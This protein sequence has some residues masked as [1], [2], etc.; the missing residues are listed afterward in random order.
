MATENTS[1]KDT[2]PAGDSN[3]STEMVIGKINTYQR[4]FLIVAG[5]ILALL[6]VIAVAGA[7]GDQ[8]L[9]S[10]AY[11]NVDGAVVH[12]DYQVDS[13]S[14]AL[15]KNV[16]GS[17]AVSENPENCCFCKPSFNCGTTCLPV[18]GLCRCRRCPGCTPPC[19]SF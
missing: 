1:L 16:F 6:V 4:T 5:S 14:L 8:H 9:Q 2:T 3:T 19:N 11:E 12:L 15:T 13:A 10:T 7:S 18:L 17:D